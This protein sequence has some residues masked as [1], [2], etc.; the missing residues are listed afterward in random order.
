MKLCTSQLTVNGGDLTHLHLHE[1]QIRWFGIGSQR[2][3]CE[4]AQWG[5]ALAMQT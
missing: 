2:C 4:V 5:E 1:Q 3:P